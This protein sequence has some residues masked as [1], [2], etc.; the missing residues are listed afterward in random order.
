MMLRPA[1][2]S[3]RVRLIAM[4]LM[5]GV[6]TIGIVPMALVEIGWSYSLIA[7]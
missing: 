2:P 4:L 5:L 6:H 7:A 1:P 3:M